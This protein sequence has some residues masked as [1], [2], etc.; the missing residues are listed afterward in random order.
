MFFIA[1]SFILLSIGSA[2]CAPIDNVLPA[3]N[4]VSFKREVSDNST[5]V[6][7]PKGSQIYGNATTTIEL[8]GADDEIITPDLMDSLS[9]LLGVDGNDVDMDVSLEELLEK[10]GIDTDEDF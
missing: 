6:I 10:F 3:N 4:T 9:G 8:S 7:P 5:I 1:T 2:Y